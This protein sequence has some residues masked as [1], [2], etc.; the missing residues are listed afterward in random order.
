MNTDPI[1]DML[2]RIRNAQA[3]QKATVVV[4]FSKVKFH[5]AK[6]LERRGF[7]KKVELRGRKTKRVFEI[8]LKY[9]K[10]NIPIISGIRRISK[11]GQRMYTPAK[12]LRRVKSGRGIAI[13]STSGGVM[14]DGEAKK[15]N[16]G[17]ELL[18]EVW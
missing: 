15:K 17:G 12:E 5:I 4:P 9:E 11:P 18:C 8:T 10:G 14:T 13:V 3:V 6:V 1:A 16:V 7:I 2:T